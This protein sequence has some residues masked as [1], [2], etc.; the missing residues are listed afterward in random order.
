MFVTSTGVRFSFISRPNSYCTLIIS[1]KYN[2]VFTP[3]EH[4]HSPETQ[5]TNFIIQLHMPWN[6]NSSFLS[7]LM[8][9]LQ[10]VYTYSWYFGNHWFWGSCWRE[11]KPTY[12]TFKYFFHERM[13]GSQNKNHDCL[14]FCFG[15]FQT[16]LLC[17][18]IVPVQGLMLPG[19][20]FGAS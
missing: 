14:L 2:D 19:V 16:K 3:N 13:R 11:L 7:I 18:Q 9:R 4:F 12:M 15:F 8:G 6:N 10:S 20:W 1:A 5:H 17:L